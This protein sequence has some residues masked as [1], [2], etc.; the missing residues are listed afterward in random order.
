[1]NRKQKRPLDVLI[2]GENPTVNILVSVSLTTLQ[3]PRLPNH[4]ILDRDKALSSLHA[5]AKKGHC[6][7]IYGSPAMGKTV[8]A[9]KFCW[10]SEDVFPD[11]IIWT[12]LGPNATSN[13]VIQEMAR[14]AGCLGVSDSLIEKTTTVKDMSALLA[15][16]I[17]NRRILFVVDDIWD[18]KVAAHFHFGGPNSC[19]L[20][21]TRN[22]QIAEE[23]A[24]NC[25]VGLGPLSKGDT[26]KL[27]E[28]Q[29]NETSALQ[30]HI[31]RLATVTGGCPLSIIIACA[32]FRRAYRINP[33]SALILVNAYLRDTALRMNMGVAVPPSLRPTYLL[34]D[35]AVSLGVA[36]AQSWSS[37][38]RAQ[39][40]ILTATTLFPADPISF[41]EAALLQA[42]AADEGDVQFL[43][44][45]SLIH[46]E[47]QGRLKVHQTVA[48]FVSQES[49]LPSE[50]SHRC[51]SYWHSF[52]E[53]NAER[54]QNALEK[55]SMEA[56]NLEHFLKQVDS[57]CDRIQ[58]VRCVSALATLLEIRGNYKHATALLNRTVNWLAAKP[59]HVHSAE[60]YGRL[61]SISEKAGNY[62]LAETLYK[63]ALKATNPSAAAKAYVY[64]NYGVLASKIGRPKQCLDLLKRALKIAR[65]TGDRA[66]MAAVL[67][68]IAAQTVRTGQFSICK[69]ALSEALG[70]SKTLR[71]PS[72]LAGILTNLG[73]LQICQGEFKL[74]SRTLE[75]ALKIE[76]NYEHRDK[77]CLVLTHLGFLD[78]KTGRIG[79][80]K[81]ILTKVTQLASRSHVQRRSL[82]KSYLALCFLMEG[83]LS[84][85]SRNVQDALKQ[86]LQLGN[87][88]N[89][90]NALIISG[91]ID[92]ANGNLL[93]AR[94]TLRQAIVLANAGHYQRLIAVARVELGNVY[95]DQGQLPAARVSFVQARTLARQMTLLEIS[96]LG[97]FG[98]A[99][100]DF[101]EGKRKSGRK[102]AEIALAILQ[103]I[104]H[105]AAQEV[106]AWLTETE[107]DGCDSNSN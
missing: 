72:R 75:R 85:A 64:Q 8:L 102:R 107:F 52:C 65:E 44:E 6:M 56:A 23:F 2:V 25:A 61:G 66:R 99:K 88:E 73:F 1:M 103:H 83:K 60:L 46:S 9:S 24:G 74:A 67:K 21:T 57:N 20:I 47:E 58:F 16:A 42:T 11:G 101:R 3:A 43:K 54:T 15:Q 95:L 31:P 80:A 41:P 55:V 50:Y 4:L 7:A 35:A 86:S 93:S 104:Q 62:R 14:A 92:A 40:L 84:S 5:F 98:L 30:K 70:L 94:R 19:V 45:A 32:N 33:S 76:S 10:E 106:K 78:L 28:D 29:L 105:S 87:R 96:A 59:D 13:T 48:D 51:L 49:R 90:V 38:S 71:D 68:N 34:E 89:I 100:A 37:L 22:A 82:A 69:R 26:C 39:Q 27:L 12:R 18:S 81:K 91:K 97:D 36:I 79:S 53:G 17:G 63:L 77:M